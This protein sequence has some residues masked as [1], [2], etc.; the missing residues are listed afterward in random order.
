MRRFI[1]AVPLA[2]AA[3]AAASCTPASEPA[4]A[5]VSMPAS[6]A[7][8]AFL[9]SFVAMDAPRFDAFFSEDATMFFP[10][11]PFPKERVAGKSAIVAAFGNLF[12]MAR[13]RG[14]A[15]LSIQPMDLQVQDLGDF[16]IATFHL[17]GNGNLGRRS[18]LMRREP[19]GWRIVHFHASS[20][21]APAG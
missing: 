2:A 18:I 16:A 12:D 13:S 8:A 9:E 11:G 21:E 7:V 20:L 10:D 4:R 5:P 15:R 14:V 19:A 3:L 17:R 6:Q 1:L